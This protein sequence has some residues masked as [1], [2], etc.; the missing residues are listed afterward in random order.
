M[1]K[2]EL[3]E[4]VIFVYLRGRR[5]DARKKDFPTSSEL[6][7]MSSSFFVTDI[8]IS[9]IVCYNI[10]YTMPIQGGIMILGL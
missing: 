10:L 1:N 6:L 9:V 3:P 2:Y 4:K 5:N 8:A 7:N